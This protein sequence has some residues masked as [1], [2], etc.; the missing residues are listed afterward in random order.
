MIRYNSKVITLMSGGK[1]VA[2]IAGLMKSLN[3][4][5]R[6]TAGV[7]LSYDDEKI[8]T[9][10][11]DEALNYDEAG[12]VTVFINNDVPERKPLINVIK[13]S[14]MIRGEIPMT[15]ECIRHESIIRLGLCEG[16]VMYDIGGGTGSVSIEAASLSRNLK[17]YS[18]EKKPEAVSLIK[19]NIAKAGLYNIEVV[20][21]NAPETFGELPAPDRVFIGGSDGK[22]SEIIKNL[23]ECKK[24]IRYV[25]NAVSLETFEEVKKLMK[26]YTVTDD[27]IVQISVTGVRKAGEHHLMSAQNP[28]WIFSFT[29]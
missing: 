14:D 6:I 10:T 21:G 4:N 15:K 2:K 16:D 22:L 13:D 11:P 23:S 26:E 17:V 12:I 20:E 8:I 29:I 27:E 28:V 24:G 7:N 3:I 1:D 18:F 19:E 9:M 5:G 25:I